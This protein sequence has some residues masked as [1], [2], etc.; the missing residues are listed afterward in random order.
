MRDALAGDK[1]TAVYV[2]RGLSLGRTNVI[3][4]AVQYGKK[5]AITSDAKEI[6]VSTVTVSFSL[7]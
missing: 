7:E 6:Q 1:F 2:I 5:D 3:A 4:T